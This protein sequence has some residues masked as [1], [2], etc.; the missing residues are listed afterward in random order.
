METRK[1][2]ALFLDGTWNV[3]TN[4]TNVWRLK[5]LCQRSGDQAVYYNQGVGTQVG[6]KIIGGMLGYGLDQ[7]VMDAYEWVIENY[8]TGDE[9]FIFGFSRGAYTARSLSGFISKCGLL[10]RGSPLGVGE[11]YERY[12]MGGVPKTIRILRN[13]KENAPNVPLSLQDEWLLKYSLPIPVKFLGV[14]DTVG[15]LGIPFGNIPGLSRSNY[16]YLE[17]DLHI[18]NS[19]AYHALAID[20][21][22]KSFEP[23][24]WTRDLPKNSKSEDLDQPLRTL[25]AVEQRWFVGAHANVGGG[26]NSDLLAQIPLKWLMDKA[27]Q[28]GLNFQQTFTVEGDVTHARIADSYGEFIY[29]IYSQFG[30]PY[31]RPIGNTPVVIDE[32]NETITVNETIDPS[33]FDRWRV[34]P[35]Y[36][37]PNLVEWAQR[38]KVD[39]G[40]LQT[41]VR[42]DDPLVSVPD[43]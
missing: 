31:Y 35:K 28:H 24:L 16:K 1:K 23:T 29:G 7:E 4:N 14:W 9:L 26:Y 22:R 5:S 30:T 39:P 20:E 8:N 12:Q 37:P 36:R 25:H 34:D 15:A 42:A 43:Q 11:L 33:V 18:N 6:S 38:K 19:F 10:Q 41:S 40:Q 3:V 13:E 27:I 2:L 21:H 32:E 17:T